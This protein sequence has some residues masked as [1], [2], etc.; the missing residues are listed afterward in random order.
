MERR[1]FF[2]RLLGGAVAAVVGWKA[3]PPLEAEW[4]PWYPGVQKIHN[5][6]DSTLYLHVD[7]KRVVV[8]PHSTVELWHNA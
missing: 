5:H 8:P 2:S 1:S 4:T 6:H 7:G 3:K